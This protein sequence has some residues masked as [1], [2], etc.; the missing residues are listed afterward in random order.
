MTNR[1]ATVSFNSL[2]LN[3]KNLIRRTNQRVEEVLP[4]LFGTN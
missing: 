4:L 3:L 2:A 1:L